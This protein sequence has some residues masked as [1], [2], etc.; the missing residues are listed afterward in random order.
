M[1]PA[2]GR[3]CA[4]LAGVLK[5][6]N[7]FAHSDAVGIHR[8]WRPGP[9]VPRRCRMHPGRDVEDARVPVAVNALHRAHNLI[10]RMEK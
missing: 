10:A 6:L 2:S 7:A 3:R 5:F 9:R 1:I 4:D 8:G